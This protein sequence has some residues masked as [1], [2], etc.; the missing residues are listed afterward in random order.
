M[1]AQINY[2]WEEY[3]LTYS[4][5]RELFREDLGELPVV[6]KQI[7]VLKDAIRKLGDVNVNAIEDFKELMERYTFLSGQRDDLC[8]LY[9][10]RCV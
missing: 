3:G 1:D 4:A 2:M 7:A 8:L 9:T 10:S 6:R 5:A